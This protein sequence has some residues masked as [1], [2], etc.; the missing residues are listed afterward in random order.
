MLRACSE[1]EGVLMGDV[2][3]E[4]PDDCGEQFTVNVDTELLPPVQGH[5]CEDVDAGL[6]TPVV[7]VGV[8]DARLACTVPGFSLD[9]NIVSGGAAEVQYEEDTP[10]A[11]GDTGTFALAVRQAE[12]GLI[13]LT[14]T[15]GDYSGIAVDLYGRVLV[16]NSQPYYSRRIDGDSIVGAGSIVIP[17]NIYSF[18]VTV[19]AIGAGVTMS[20]PDFTSGPVAMFDGQSIG[21]STSDGPENDLNGPITITTTAGSEVNA[22]WVRS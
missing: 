15:D 12:G 22:T 7:H 14:D 11:S 1:S 8:I 9:V 16:R 20:G 17:G 19:G 2:P 3:V 6:G 5:D 18:A 21:H 10:H 13:P 4:V